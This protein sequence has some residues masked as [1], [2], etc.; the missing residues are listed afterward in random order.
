[1]IISYIIIGVLLVGFITMAVVT[2]IK[3]KKADL[4]A[5]YE[6]SANVWKSATVITGIMFIVFI[7]IIS[8][9]IHSGTKSVVTDSYRQEIAVTSSKAPRYDVIKDN[10]ADYDSTQS[11][12][13]IYLKSG[14][15]KTISPD[16][17]HIQHGSKSKSYLI[18]KHMQWVVT[19]FGM[20]SYGGKY[21]AYDLVLSGR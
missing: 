5:R 10:N 17:V 16:V 19:M 13:K 18:V 9:K 20:K 8:F 7:C 14:G 4:D 15:S 11:T 6:A 1:M 3:A 21:T 2:E 12:Y